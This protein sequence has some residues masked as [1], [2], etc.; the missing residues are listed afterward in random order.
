[1]KKLLIFIFML[2][3]AANANAIVVKNSLDSL[4]VQVRSL[5][6]DLAQKMSELESCAKKTKNFQIA[7]GITLGLTAAGAAVNISQYNKQKSQK[8]QAGIIL[9]KL[10][11]EEAE[12]TKTLADIYATDAEQ[13]VVLEKMQN[14]DRDKVNGLINNNFTKSELARIVEIGNLLE[15][16]PD[17][18]LGDSDKNLLL[19]ISNL[20]YKSSL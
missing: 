13:R 2:C 19:K 16:N 20:V 6:S 4:D 9:A 17:M 10:E 14:V 1:M 18:P 15:S 7:G 12:K 3:A 5:E 11:A 8:A